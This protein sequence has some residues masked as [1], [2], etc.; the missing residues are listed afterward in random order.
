MEFG[1]MGIDIDSCTFY[2]SKLLREETKNGRKHCF[3]LVSN[4]T[5]LLTI[6]LSWCGVELK[7]V[8]EME[9]APHISTTLSLLE[10]TEQT[11][12]QTQFFDSESAISSP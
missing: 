9:V 10:K 3:C 5:F 4:G 6:Q 12:A 7:S 2:Q 11:P 8:V 1:S